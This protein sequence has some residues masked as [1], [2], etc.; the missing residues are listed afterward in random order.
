MAD[1]YTQLANTPVG[2][3][4]TRQVGL[5]APV[6]LRRD[7]DGDGDAER[8]ARGSVLFAAAPGGRLEAQIVQVLAD[9][10]AP[11]ARLGTEDARHRYRQALIFDATGIVDTQGLQELQAFFSASIRALEPCGRVVV[12]GSPPADASA[13]SE[14][15]A[16]RALEGFTRSLGK[17]LR[18]GATAQLVYVAPGAEPGLASTLRFLLSPRSAYVS[19]QVVRVGPADP[20]AELDWERPQ[21]GRVALVTGASR[22]I[23]ASIA[24]TLARDGAH[25]V[26]IDLPALADDLQAVARTLGG[27]AL[28]LD[29]TAADA[30]VRIAAHLRDAHGGVDVVVHNAGITRDRTL[31]RMDAE[32]WDGVIDGQPARAGAD[33]RRAD[34]RRRAKRASPG[35]AGRLRVVDQRHR[36]NAGQ[37]NYATSKAGVIGMVDAYAPLLTARRATIN[38]VAPG[39]HRDADDGQHAVRAARSRTAHELALPGRPAGGCRRDDRLACLARL[40][41]RQRKRRSRLRTEPAGGVTMSATRELHE[42]PG[43]LDMLLRASLPMIPG[44]SRLPFVAGGGARSPTRC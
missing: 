23:G 5:P 27:S 12:L 33:H 30:P 37:T 9:A 32:R 2:R 17:E 6:P 16:Q 7:G 14:A 36:G 3:V 39:I 13:P 19:G 44:A 20:P 11:L 22:G 43:A 28:A 26:G 25:V 38:A 41:R 31:G 34:R 15:I 10:G 4:L 24:A 40:R 1:I 21:Q 8:P 42:P 29:I 35:R 18:R